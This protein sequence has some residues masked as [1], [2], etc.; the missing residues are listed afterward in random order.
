M[1]KPWITQMTEE[2]EAARMIGRPVEEL[3]E[4]VRKGLLEATSA[5]QYTLY[6]TED[7]LYIMSKLPPIP[8]LRQRKAARFEK[9][10]LR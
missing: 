5:G 7:I 9:A 10:T 3:R 8:G 1:R 2:S 4:A 6:Q